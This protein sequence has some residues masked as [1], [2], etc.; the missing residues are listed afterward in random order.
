M[1]SGYSWRP[2]KVQLITVSHRQP[3]WVVAGCAEYERR[4]PREWSYSVVELK[5]VTR[6]GGTT[7]DKARATEGERIR[8]AVAKGARLIVLDE[9]GEAWTTEKFA[10]RMTRWAR[11]GRDLAF[12]IGGADGLDPALVASAEG[13]LSLSAFTM[14]HGLVR[15]VFAEQLYRV[16]SLNAGHPYHRA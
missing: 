16:A 12:V 11:D 13:R 8:A 15:V 5:P 14:P 9:R 2:V 10:E 7:V 6:G 1:A 3:D 4:L